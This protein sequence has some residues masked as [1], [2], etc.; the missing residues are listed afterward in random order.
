[1]STS[2]DDVPM[3][4]TTPDAPRAIGP[5]SHATIDSGVLF[6]SGQLP[7]DPKTGELIAK[8]PGEQARQCLT[9]LQAVCRAA[10][11][12]LASGALRLGV[13][14]TDL[15]AV[16][17]IDAAFEDIFVEY[18]PAR[19]IAQVSGLPRGAAVQIDAVVSLGR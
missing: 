9:N 3:S 13:F 19:S 8:D 7:I 16:D 4:I 14:V 18:R 11:T 2:H 5:Y 1:M 12:D 15:S 17:E 6:C 10:L